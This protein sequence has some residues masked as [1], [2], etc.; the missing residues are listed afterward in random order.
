MADNS[1]GET[2]PQL[3]AKLFSQIEEESARIREIQAS[4]NRDP[5]GRDEVL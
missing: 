1:P 2:G 5:E 4:P 3:V